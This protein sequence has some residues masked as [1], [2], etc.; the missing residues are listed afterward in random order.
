MSSQAPKKDE[1]KTDQQVDITITVS[2]GNASA[3]ADPDPAEM[4]YGTSD[5]ITWTIKTEGYKFQTNP[6]GI[7]FNDSQLTWP[8]PDPTRVSDVE[9]TVDDPT[10]AFGDQMN[11]YGY[12]INFESTASGITGMSDP[13]IDD[14][15]EI[16]M[17]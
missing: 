2:G 12:D 11:A 13:E 6:A 17:G 3:S 7:V 10:T 15:S 14:E 9:Y 8:G 1:P 16:K 5:T 4:K